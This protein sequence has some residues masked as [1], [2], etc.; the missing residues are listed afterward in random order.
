MILESKFPV[1][2]LMTFVQW[3]P[4]SLALNLNKLNNKI[5]NISYSG[6]FHQ[7]KNAD[8]PET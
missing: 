6:E 1:K 8:A 4:G 3:Q 5:C 7:R 2:M